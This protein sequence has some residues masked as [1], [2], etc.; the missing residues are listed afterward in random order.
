MNPFAH[1]HPARR[2]TPIRL[3][4]LGATLALAPTAAAATKPVVATGGATAVTYQS[5]TLHGTV[6]PEAQPTTYFFQYGPTNRYGSQGNPVNLAAGT[7]AVG[8]QSPIGGLLPRSKYHY[9]VVAVSAAGTALG[10]DAT[11]TTAAIPLSLAIGALPSPV[12]FGAPLSIVGTL[13]GTGAGGRTVVLQANPFPYPGFQAFGN[14]QVTL[15][16]GA[17]Q[18]NLLS[19][20][21]TT[22]FRVV[23]GGGAQPVVISPTVTEEVALAVTM[24]VQS[25]RIRPGS[26]T[27]R[28]S[29]TVTPAEVG[30][31]VSIQRLI[32]STW[33]FV[34]ATNARPASAGSSTY[35][36][37]IRRSHGGFF[38]VFVAPVEGGHAAN[39]SPPAL[40][41]AGAS[42]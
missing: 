34:S 41:H 35:S 37:T 1:R 36:T 12:V 3:A 24:H 20:P 30:A 17:F 25:H 7:R 13:S 38:R 29:G 28:F 40:V 18:F 16:T 27:M 42:F 23:S 15:P 6:N 8:V 33:R 4:V 39:S 22:Q 5:A 9:R 19:L 21:M 14:A 32:G 26:Y 2:R 11:F 31:R 10:G